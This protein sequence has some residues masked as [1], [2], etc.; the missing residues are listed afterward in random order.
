VS[1]VWRT[2]GSRQVIFAFEIFRNVYGEISSYIQFGS[3]T[4]WLKR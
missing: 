4:H 2:R 1:L 3:R